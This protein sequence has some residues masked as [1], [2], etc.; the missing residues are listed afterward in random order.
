MIQN[1]SPSLPALVS[2]VAVFTTT[3]HRQIL[4]V[5]S[6]NEIYTKPDFDLDGVQR[7][8][9]G[10]DTTTKQ[11]LKGAIVEK[12]QVNKGTQHIL[13]STL[14]F[15]SCTSYSLYISYKSL[16][17]IMLWS[18]T[19]FKSRIFFSD[20]NDTDCISQHLVYHE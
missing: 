10:Q 4:R 1:W 9:D 19:A 15:I 7:L 6:G 16:W 20:S 13:A 14:T 11:Y 8:L 2:D 12:S 3:K 5:T 17:D 18:S